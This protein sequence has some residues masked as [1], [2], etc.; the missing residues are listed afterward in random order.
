[1]FLFLSC[2][3]Y[4]IFSSLTSIS[5][6]VFLVAS[7]VKK[8]SSKRILFL[9]VMFIY[10]ISLLN[11]ASLLLISFSWLFFFVILSCY[12][13]FY[14]KD[15][16]FFNF[17]NT[18]EKYSRKSSISSIIAKCDFCVSHIYIYFLVMSKY[19]CFMPAPL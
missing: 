11:S 13:Y 3:F 9:K 1:M 12:K 10:S 17:K 2:S 19:I 5:Q 8:F 15:S 4:L 6:S 18:T 16:I 14:R 7:I